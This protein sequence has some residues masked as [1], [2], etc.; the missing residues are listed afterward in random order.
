MRSAELLDD[1]AAPGWRPFFEVLLPA[2]SALLLPPGWLHE[3]TNLGPCSAGLSHVVPRFAGGYFGRFYGRLAKAGALEACP[4]AELL[5]PAQAR[6]LAG[7]DLALDLADVPAVPG[8]PAL[9]RPTLEDLAAFYDLD[10]DGASGP[11]EA[12]EAAERWA[13]TLASLQREPRT[14]LEDLRLD[15]PEPE[16]T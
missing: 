11:A 10:G 2:G 15:W 5:A 4:L 12:R 8:A 1:G 9:P 7:A 16:P 3:T 13:R 6:L 14:R